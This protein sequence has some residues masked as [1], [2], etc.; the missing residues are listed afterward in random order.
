MDSVSDIS[1]KSN[2]QPA[3]N[4]DNDIRFS[5]KLPVE[6][7]A[8]LIAW[9]NI[10]SSAIDEAIELGGLAMPSFAVKP[11]DSVHSSYGDIS[12]IARKDSIDPQRNRSSRIFACDAWTPVF[13]EVNYKIDSVA[14]DKLDSKIKGLLEKV[15]VKSSD[16]DVAL[17]PDNIADR[18]MLK[19]LGKSAAVYVRKNK[20]NVV[21]GGSLL[22]SGTLNANIKFIEDT[23]SQPFQ[24]SNTQNKFD[25][26]YFAAIDRGDMEAVQRMVDEAADLLREGN[27]KETERAFTNFNHRGDKCLRGSPKMLFPRTV[28]QTITGKTIPKIPAPASWRLQKN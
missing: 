13:P 8:D 20:L 26:E 10:S 17:D 3:K 25:A 1:E 15:G 23:L 19:R 11:A 7:T 2:I 22:E 24:K 28:Y 5:M 27:I 18:L 21:P 9:H 12:V 14:A 4:T 6:E 16:I